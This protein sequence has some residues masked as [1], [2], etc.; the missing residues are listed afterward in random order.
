MEPT[1]EQVTREIRRLGFQ[2]QRLGQLFAAAHGLHETDM[3]ALLHVLTHE[4]QG[5]PLTAGQL[6][7]VLGLSSGAVTAVVDRLVELGYTERHRDSLDRRRVRLH[8]AGPGMALADAFFRPLGERGRQVMAHFTGD[9]L[10]VVLRFLGELNAT[11]EE[12]LAELN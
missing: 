1:Q 4:L 10:A 12:R 11:Y 7:E 5:D 9:E 2:L 8:H 3:T 6:A